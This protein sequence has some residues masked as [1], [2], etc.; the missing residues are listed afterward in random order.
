[1][2]HILLQRFSERWSDADSA[3]AAYESH[4]AEVHATVSSNRLVEWRPGDGW[5]PIC[6]ALGLAV[7]DGPFPHSNTTSEFRACAG[8][9]IPR[10]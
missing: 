1:M 4:N 5:A 9:D 7:P 3:M 2:L 10:P 6:E 8:F